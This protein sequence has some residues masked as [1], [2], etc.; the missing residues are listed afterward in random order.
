MIA[1]K[2]RE[3]AEREKAG[4]YAGPKDGKFLWPVEG[5]ILTSGYGYRR[6]P[7]TGAYK[8]H[9]GIDIGAPLGTPIRAVAEGK[10]IES[11]PASGYGYIVVI[12]HGGGLSTLYAHVY[13][14]DVTVRVG[15]SVS[16]GQVIAA[17]GNNGQSTGPHLH[18]EV[19]KDGRTVDPKP[20]FR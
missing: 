20:Y 8:L 10:V 14:Q 3:S 17:V 12:D 9:E 7:V 18:L 2:T 15:Q 13:P 16:R 5:G 19:I 6:N 11:R 1:R 4:Q